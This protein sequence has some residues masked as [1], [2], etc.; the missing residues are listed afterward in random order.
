MNGQDEAEGRR[1][2]DI[3]YINNDA[4]SGCT[5]KQI[6]EKMKKRHIED[7]SKNLGQYYFLKV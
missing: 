3:Q 6:F 7:F 5:L 1:R 2:S 4:I